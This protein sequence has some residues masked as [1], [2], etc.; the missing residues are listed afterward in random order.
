MLSNESGLLFCK[1]A[2]TSA[3]YTVHNTWRTATQKNTKKK[4]WKKE[5]LLSPFVFLFRMPPG[6][7]LSPPL[8]FAGIKVTTFSKGCLIRRSAVVAGP[9]GC[10]QARLCATASAGEIYPVCFGTVATCFSFWADMHLHSLERKTTFSQK[11]K[12]RGAEAGEVRCFREGFFTGRQYIT[13]L[14]FLYLLCFEGTSTLLFMWTSIHTVTPAVW[15]YSTST[16]CYCTYTSCSQ[17]RL[18]YWKL[19]C[20]YVSTCVSVCVCVRVRVRATVCQGYSHIHT[21]CMNVWI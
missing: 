18:W 13:R 4:T 14:V 19:L 9:R 20:Y 12:K 6:T 10:C 8:F 3:S 21:S 16:K 15:L 11:E 2:C 7:L 17:V 1:T 5:I